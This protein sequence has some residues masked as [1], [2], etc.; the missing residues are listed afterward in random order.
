[1]GPTSVTAVECG[2]P[3]QPP[4]GCGLSVTGWFAATAPSRMAALAL[5]RTVGPTTSPHL[6]RQGRNLLH[7]SMFALVDRARG[8]V[9]L[10]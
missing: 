7:V 6:H 4:A 8:G 9:K 5:A 10:H 2:H 1:V 3:F